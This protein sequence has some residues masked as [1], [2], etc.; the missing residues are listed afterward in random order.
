[1]STNLLQFCNQTI[2]SGDGVFPPLTSLFEVSS[3]E[4]RLTGIMEELLPRC[5]WRSVSV[6]HAGWTVAA[7]QVRHSDFP[8]KE[9]AVRSTV[10]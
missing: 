8:S 2:A 7:M 5:G 4:E 10:G 3:Q 1:M 9:L 6:W